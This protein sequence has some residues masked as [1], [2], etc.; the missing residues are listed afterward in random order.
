MILVDEPEYSEWDIP[1]QLNMI[2]VGATRDILWYSHLSALELWKDCDHPL[3]FVGY[4][5]ASLRQRKAPGVL[6]N[7][8]S[9]S[10]T[11]KRPLQQQ[12]TKLLGALTYGGF[13]KWGVPPNGWSISENPIN[14]DLGVPI[15]Q[16]TPI[17]V[18][19]S[20]KIGN[21]IIP[22]SQLTD[23]FFSGSSTKQLVTIILHSMVP[24]VE[25]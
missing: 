6:E 21:F 5:K 16:E 1:N 2:W 24:L 19:C 17:F 9:S 20:S 18:F 11:Q 8:P 15:F 23:I 25:D 3:N 4:C 7:P 12:S 10:M 14:M 22:T 13:L